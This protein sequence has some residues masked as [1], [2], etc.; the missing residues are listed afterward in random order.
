MTISI[1]RNDCTI[2]ELH[3]LAGM[4]KDVRQSRRFRGACDGSGRRLPK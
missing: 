3:R 1:A 4:C 2:E